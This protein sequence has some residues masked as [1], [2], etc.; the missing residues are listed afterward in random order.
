[1]YL[2]CDTQQVPPPR[3]PRPS[4]DR[5]LISSQK[6]GKS[7]RGD[8]FLAFIGIVPITATLLMELIQTISIQQCSGRNLH[9]SRRSPYRLFGPIS[10]API[11]LLVPPPQQHVLKILVVSGERSSAGAK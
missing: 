3:P 2:L 5:I 8:Q 1:V 4:L 11:L 9:F 6:G 10:H 7:G